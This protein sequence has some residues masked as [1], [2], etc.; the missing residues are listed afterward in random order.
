VPE[1]DSEK[2]RNAHKGYYAHINALDDCLAM[3]LKTIGQEG[4][5][6]NTIFV[7]TSDHGDMLYSHGGTNKQQPYN[8]SVLVPFLLR[9]PKV[10]GTKSR[11]IH[12][13]INT[14]DILPT[15]LGLCD[16]KVPKSVEGDDFSKVVKG[17]KELKDNPVLISSITPFGQWD[18]KRGGTEYRGI[19]TKRYTYVRNLDGPWMLFDNQSDP[20][21]QT[22]LI[23]NP[24]YSK[25]EANL[26]KILKQKLR[27]TNDEFLP[28]Q[29]YIEKWGYV[30]DETGTIP[31]KW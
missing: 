31:W 30:V 6:E 19:R 17:E 2:S 26:E 20:Y 15:L 5:A 16:I 18:R 7:F 25:L 4:I 13:P 14:Q 10:H 8:E 11:T 22:N 28:G 12:A 9:Y 27:D 23:G 3:L 1:K 21:Q 29:S 24:E